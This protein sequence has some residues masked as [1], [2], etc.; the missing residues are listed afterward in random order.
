MRALFRRC[1]RCRG[2]VTRGNHLCEPCQL[3]AA[4][5]DDALRRPRFDEMMLVD[6]P[7]PAPRAPKPPE[8]PNHPVFR[9]GRDASA[10]PVA[11]GS[12]LVLPQR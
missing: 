6:E 7:L 2:R 12:D 10:A 9:S 3:Q 5:E 4:N 11:R 8:S 1:G